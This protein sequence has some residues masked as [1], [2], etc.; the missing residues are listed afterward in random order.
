MALAIY[1][2]ASTVRS[3][4][5]VASCDDGDKATGISAAPLLFMSLLNKPKLSA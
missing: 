3:H 2:D 5:N 4:H 1:T